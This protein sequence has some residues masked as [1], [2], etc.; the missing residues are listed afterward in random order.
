MTEKFKLAL[1]TLLLFSMAGCGGVFEDSEPFKIDFQNEQ[2]TQ[3]NVTVIV[4][5]DESNLLVNKTMSVAPDERKDLTTV[6]SFSSEELNVTILNSTGVIASW[7]SVPVHPDCGSGVTID[8]KDNDS[9]GVD[10]SAGCD[11]WF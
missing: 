8:L 6:D 9:V 1:I 3:R 5:D 2:E 7:G 11:G 4:E 10:S